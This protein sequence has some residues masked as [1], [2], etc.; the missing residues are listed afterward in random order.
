MLHAPGD[1]RVEEIPDPVLTHDHEAI[2]RVVAACVCGS[3]L[4]PFRGIDQRENLPSQIGHEFIGVVEQLGASVERIKVGDF[5]IA[6]FLY[7][8]GTCPNC[9]NGITPACLNGGGYVG[10][11][12][13]LVSVP[14]ADGTLYSLPQEPNDDLLPHLLALSD[15][16]PTGHHAAISARVTPGS[17]VAVVGDGAVGLGAVLAAK[18]LGATIIV[19]MS[20]HTERAALAREFGATHVVEA[21]GKEGAAA[22]RDIVGAIGADAVLEC[23]GTTESLKQAFLSLRP[24]GFVGYVG[25]PHDP[26]LNIRAMFAKNTGLMG[27]IAPVRAYLDELVPEVLSGSLQPGKVFDLTLPLS[28]AAEAYQAMDERRAIKAMLLP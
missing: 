11:Q 4:W 7:S 12:A 14:Q 6:P 3:D 25:I 24:G 16:F 17:S 8:C 9:L 15:V 2:V 21:R 18:R 13:E 5:V 20:R 28:H 26:A 27:G 10:C 23:V 22:V 1:I 19:A